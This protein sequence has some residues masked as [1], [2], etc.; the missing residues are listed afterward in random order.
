MNTDDKLVLTKP[1]GRKKQ[2]VVADIRHLI[3]EKGLHGLWIAGIPKK[4][5]RQKNHKEEAALC[6]I[7][8]CFLEQFMIESHYTRLYLSA[9]QGQVGWP[10]EII[11]IVYYRNRFPSIIIREVVLKQITSQ[12]FPN[13][14]KS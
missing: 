5:G 2:D 3:L 9:C 11:P 4:I 1:T 10:E 14:T 6:K 13:G 12:I 8:A 7:E